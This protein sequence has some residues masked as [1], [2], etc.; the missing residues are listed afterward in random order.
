MWNSIACILYTI[1][2]EVLQIFVVFKCIN[3]TQR[4]K[5]CFWILFLYT[6]VFSVI[7]FNLTAQISYVDSEG[8][9]AAV[10]IVHALD[11]FILLGIVNVFSEEFLP[12]NFLLLS[13][14]YDFLTIIP[15]SNLL[16]GMIIKYLQAGGYSTYYFD[17]DQPAELL[18]ILV[19]SFKIFLIILV[20]FLFNRKL[21]PLLTKIPDS[22]CLL[23]MSLFFIMLIIRIV[24]TAKT[25]FITNDTIFLSLFYFDALLIIISIIIIILI[26]IYALQNRRYKML[27]KI[28]TA[29]QLSYY[30]NVSEIYTEVR[31]LKHDIA[32][33]LAIVN[34]AGTL[35]DDKREFY[36]N[37]L[38]KTCDEINHKLDMQMSWKTTEHSFLSNRE[39]YEIYNY[40]TRLFSKHHIT[41]AE[42]SSAV[43]TPENPEKLIF[44]TTYDSISKL[45]LRKIKYAA[46]HFLIKEIA[47]Q[48]NC[49]L[50]FTDDSQ[51]CTVILEKSST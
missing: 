22:I 42:T 19:I 3:V 41:S 45:K 50:L 20:S 1:N 2:F 33:H 34:A 31:S 24:L 29:M 32:N 18:P 36:K 38:L 27:Q 48:H 28:E 8:L 43:S 7:Q 44:H 40:I 49:T 10:A 23:V 30:R 4:K 15:V 11:T 9:K 21:K 13:F 35:S 6:L 16:Q 46:T 17:A 37:Q 5:T 26:I 47:Q 14:Y 25:D 39:E 12:R 51:S